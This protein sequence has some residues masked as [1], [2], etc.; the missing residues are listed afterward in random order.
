MQLNDNEID[1]TLSLINKHF[2]NDLQIYKYTDEL[3]LLGC[4]IDCE[5][6]KSHPI[7]DIIGENI[8]DYLPQCKNYLK[9]HSI[10]NEIQMLL[11]NHH[12]NQ[13]R[14]QDGLLEINS[15]WLWDNDFSKKDFA[16]ITPT[17]DINHYLGIN[18]TSYFYIDNL[19][20]STQYRDSFAW[21]NNL[22]Q[23]DLTLFNQL[24][25]ALKVHKQINLVIPQTDK[26]YLITVKRSNIT[27]LFHKNNYIKLIDKSIELQ[28]T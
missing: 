6:I 8:D 27:N 5:E 18:H 24:L 4:N 1:T 11:F 7:I 19:L 25:E 13:Q 15:I 23:L 10:I 12:I 2:A 3:W 26:S 17:L 9:L 21:I 16:I 22:N 28:T 14:K 20:Y